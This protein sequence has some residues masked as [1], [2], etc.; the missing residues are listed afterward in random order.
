MKSEE[1]YEDVSVDID[2]ELE[3]AAERV[4]Q[5][6]A[7]KKHILNIITKI[8]IEEAAAVKSTSVATLTSS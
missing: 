3:A 6:P 4:T 1:D 8:T 2:A 7:I 5:T